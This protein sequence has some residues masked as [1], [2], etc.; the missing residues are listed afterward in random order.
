MTL[1]ATIQPG[2][3]RT[4]I[5]ATDQGDDCLKAVLPT[6]PVHPRALH[7]LLEGLALWHGEPVHAA[8]VA[9]GPSGLSR[10]EDLFGGGLW[11]HD[12]ANVRFDIHHPRRARRI[13]GPGDFRRLYLLHG[14]GR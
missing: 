12:L 8:L 14:G 4:R 7:T 1:H 5:L 6:P 3:H 2:P 11:P 9:D 10:V 13:R